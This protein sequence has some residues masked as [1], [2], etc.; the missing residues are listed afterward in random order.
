MCQ[1]MREA[2]SCGGQCSVCGQHEARA[3]AGKGN[4]HK[5]KWY[6]KQLKDVEEKIEQLL[7][8]CDEID[9][10]E[11][12]CGS[13]VSMPKELAQSR[14]LKKSIEEALSEFS[15]RGD[16]TKDGKERNVN[17]VDPERGGE[18]P[19]GDASGYSMQTVVDDKMGLSWAP[20]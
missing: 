2:G 5:K 6:E 11:S 4:L 8:Q 18:K 14:K 17:R 19:S 1:G 20:M 10:R 7:S 15:K 9:E 3:S 13:M 16:K 12:Q